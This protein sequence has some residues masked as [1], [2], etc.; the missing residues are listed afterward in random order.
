VNIFVFAYFTFAVS[1]M[2]NYIG[3][4]F[5][6]RQNKTISLYDFILFLGASLI[7]PIIVIFSLTI[8][9]R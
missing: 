2:A 5:F 1:F 7:W 4:H 8:W 6:A 9:K 3:N